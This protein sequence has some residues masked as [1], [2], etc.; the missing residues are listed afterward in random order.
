MCESTINEYKMFQCQVCENLEIYEQIRVI[1]K[2][3]EFKSSHLCSN[4]QNESI[5]IEEDEK[6]KC[7]KCHRY[8]ICKEEIGNWD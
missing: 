1:I 3:N 7:P 4:C 8:T 2:D 6:I 5:E